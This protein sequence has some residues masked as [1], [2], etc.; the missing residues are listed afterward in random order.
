MLATMSAPARAPYGRQSDRPDTRD[1]VIV[2]G[3]FRRAFGDLPWLI[4]DVGAGD[5]ARAAVLADFYA[6][7]R[8]GLEHH[9]ET[10][11]ELLW[12]LLLARA[13]ADRAMVLRAEEQHE[14]IHEILERADLQI[15]TFRVCADGLARDALVTTL[16]DLFAAL[17]EHLE[18]EE[19]HIL[20]LAEQHLSASEWAQ[21]GA[22]ARARIP[23][24]RLLI[25]LGWLLEGTSQTERREFLATLPRPARIAW[26]V[27]GRRR[28]ARE[29][30]RIYEN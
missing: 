6:E 4:G 26:R 14:R 8:T 20:P 7:A 17:T 10:E 29:R 27:A 25:Q 30:A 23:R 5:V 22:R 1:M 12:P 3:M 15:A 21:L 24:D 11:D 2:H 28:F 9:H 19:Q 13:A 18:E 16:E